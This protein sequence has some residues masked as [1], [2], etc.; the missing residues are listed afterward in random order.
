M[1]ENEFLPTT[2]EEMTKLGWTDLDF[3]LVS[4]DAYVDHPSFGH[5]IIS[6]VLVNA[7]YKVGIIDQPDFHNVDDFKRLGKPKYGF[8]VS[9]GNLDSM[10]NMYTTNKK[11][12]RVDNYSPAGEIGKR[13]KRP[14]IVYSNLIREAYGDVSIII[15]GVGPSLR[16]M[17]HYDYWDDKIR[18]SILFDSGADMLIYGMGEKQILEIADN[19]K[20]G[21]DIE[22]INH[23]PGTC[24][25]KNSLDEL[26]D[27]I[28]MPSYQEIC[29]SKEKYAEA[30]KIYYEEQ[31]PILGKVLVQRHHNKYVV[32]NPPQLV[33]NRDELDWIY[34]L[35]YQRNYHPKY[36]KDGGILALREVKFSIVSARGCLGNC[37]FCS[38]TFHQGRIVQSRSH[39]SIIRE[40]NMLKNDKDFKGYIHDI[41]GPTANF[42]QPAC[43]HQLKR[44]SCKVKQCLFPKPCNEINVDHS[45]YLS[46]LRKMRNVEGIKK[47]FIRSGIRYDYLMADKNDEFFRELCEHH[48]SGQLKVAPEHVSDNVLKYMNKPSKDVYEKFVDKFYKINEELNKEQ[49]IIPYLI[50]SHPGSTLK[51]AVILAEYLN[52]TGYVPEQVQ[53]FYPTPGTLST[54][55]YYT[56]IDPRSME[57]IYVPK[58]VKE[59]KMQRALL[60]FSHRRNYD[61]VYEALITLNRWDLIGD[62]KKC[63]IKAKN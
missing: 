4:A 24:F 48:V 18:H 26:Y 36:E 6:R 54:C 62:S 27:Y 53:D 15:G 11:L 28:E 39:E 46:L 1:L 2:E 21:L 38:I 31:N 55:M 12:R 7:G 41:G 52:K 45:D 17:A 56:E 10:V 25:I 61:L 16:R 32:Q 13:P 57:K 19:L 8:L 42:R 40:V 49:Y 29:D 47:V 60:Q 58:T 37:S 9:A 44:G 30:F 63:L 43:E 14:S 5:A 23:V 35:P 50:S 22:Y 51:D 59:K 3:V 20:N 34:D 33:L